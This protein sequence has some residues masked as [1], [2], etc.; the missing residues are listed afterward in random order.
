MRSHSRVATERRT[1]VLRSADPG[2][3]HIKYYKGD[4]RGDFRASVSPTP[5]RFDLRFGTSVESQI[6][7][8][9]TARSS[10]VE[11]NWQEHKRCEPCEVGSS[12]RESQKLKRRR[13]KIDI[14]CA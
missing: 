7:T 8:G 6:A 12:A 9:S 1:A 3:P 14:I 10:V 11:T 4:R 5:V 2:K 13:K